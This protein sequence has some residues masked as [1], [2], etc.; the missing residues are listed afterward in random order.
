MTIGLSG[1]H[2]TGKTTLARAFVEQNPSWNLVETTVSGVY[3]EMGLDPKVM[4]PF[5]KRLEI[6]RRILDTLTKQYQQ[7]GM[8]F[9]AD[10]TPLDFIGYTLSDVTRSY[11]GSLD[12]EI[13]SY[14]DDCYAITNTYFSMIL[15]VQPGL[16]KV[17]EAAMKAPANLG[18]MEHLNMLILG[19]ATDTRLQCMHFALNRT[20]I[21]LYRRVGAVDSMLRACQERV[22]REEC[23]GTLH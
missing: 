19:A 1:S 10:R 13:A 21:D 6:Q 23:I 22:L 16:D 4:Y 9:V 14:I 20:T 5:K 18:Y 12:K 3:A 11:D 8:R 17:E 7:G 15:V 2:R